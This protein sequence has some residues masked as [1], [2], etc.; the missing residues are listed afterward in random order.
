[1]T[2]GG[3]ISDG[4]LVGTLVYPLATSIVFG[5][6]IVSLTA[7]KATTITLSN[8]TYPAGLV[9]AASTS[10]AAAIDLSAATAVAGAP[11][12]VTGFNGTTVNLAGLKTSPLGT[13]TSVGAL[14]TVNLTAYNEPAGLLT[15][16]GPTTVTLPALVAGPISLPNATTVNLGMANG[17]QVPAGI[18]VAKYITLGAISTPVSFPASAVTISV[19]GKA[20][21]VVPMPGIGAW[22]EVSAA[23]LANLTTLSLGGTITTAFVAGNPLLT[24]LTTTGVVNSLEV[25]TNA[26]LVGM[27]LGHTHYVGGPGSTMKVI[28]NVKLASLTTSV[29]KL[30]LLVVT[31]N[32]LLTSA[33]FASYVTPLLGGTSTITINT[34]KFSGNF[35]PAIAATFT[36]P[37]F[38]T[39]VTSPELA[40]LKAYVAATA[41]QLL[42]A[43]VTLVI[44]VDLDLVNL[45]SAS[46]ATPAL[47]S[48]RTVA[49]LAH[50]PV[51]GG[52]GFTSAADFKLVQ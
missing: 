37:Y 1:M 35:V 15:V 50:L 7:A 44:N 20:N 21:T 9:V 40:T 2:V 36:T 42:P 41:A 38:Q 22:A 39:Q 14:G 26:T 32:V 24:S 11:L 19:T 49:D 23:G 51:Y 6:N 5:G 8:A 47:L 25:N 13:S 34:N 12:S 4:V 29:D 45:N 31:G 10:A 17:T 16:S 3:T 52:P 48:A 43:P 30:N 46:P 28:N 33:N 27:S 18:P